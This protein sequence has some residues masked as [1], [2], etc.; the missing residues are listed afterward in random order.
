MADEDRVDPN[1][2]A[3]EA[4]RVVLAL[5]QTQ[6]APGPHRVLIVDDEPSVRRMVRRSMASV[7]E[8][9]HV[10]EA[11]NGQEALEVLARIREEEG[12]EPDLI[13]TDLVMPVMDGWTFIEH[14]RQE[15]ETQGREYGVPVVVLSSSSGTKRRLFAKS[16]SVHG[17]RNRYRPM[18]T[19]AKEDCLKPVQYDARGEGGILAWVAF[20]LRVS[21]RG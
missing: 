20:F 10:Y 9:V 1:E 19:V 2:T 4:E 12:T 6:E 16:S 14:L 7:A 13:V 8:N 18:A 15:C 11:E 21:G 5:R 17:W 3:A